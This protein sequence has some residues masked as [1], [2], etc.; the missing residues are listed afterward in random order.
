MNYTQQELKEKVLKYFTINV[1]EK[2]LK[3]K[4]SFKQEFKKQITEE[5]KKENPKIIQGPTKD[6]YIYCLGK[7]EGELVFNLRRIINGTKNQINFLIQNGLYKDETQKQR[8]FEKQE[9]FNKSLIEGGKRMWS[10]PDERKRRI[11]INQE[12]NQRLDKKLKVRQSLQ[13]YWESDRCIEHK[14]KMKQSQFSLVKQQ[15][16]KNNVRE[17]KSLII[18]VGNKKINDVEFIFMSCLKHLNI[19]FELEKNYCFDGINYFPDF[20]LPKYNLVIEMYGDYWHRNPKYFDNE[21]ERTKGIR[22]KDKKRQETFLNKG[23]RYTYFWEDTIKNNLQ[24]VF[25]FLNFLKDK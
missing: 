3:I 24:S 12:I 2:T 18:E 5:A 25:K 14:K 15:I 17:N 21:D 4:C 11:A 19:D 6:Y 13:T 22:E 10:N 20:Y 1:D 16:K 9:A 8:L 7:D 23:F